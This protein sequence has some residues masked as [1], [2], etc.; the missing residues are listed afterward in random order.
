ME[1]GWGGW[2]GGEEERRR[3]GEE[4]GTG[5]SSAVVLLIGT[6]PVPNSAAEEG[7]GKERGRKKGSSGQR[8]AGSVGREEVL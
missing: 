7:R 8:G 5:C 1:V 6:E 3:G 4:E 2:G